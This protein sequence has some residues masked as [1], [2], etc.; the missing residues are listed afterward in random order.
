MGRLVRVM[1]LSPAGQRNAERQ[2]KQYEAKS[3]RDPL[4]WL[5]RI[6]GHTSV[7]LRNPLFRTR[8]EAPCMKMPGNVQTPKRG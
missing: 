6:F 1:L 7:W 4:N 8:R 2:A 3:L 5:A